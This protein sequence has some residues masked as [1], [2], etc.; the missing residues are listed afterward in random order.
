MTM[1]HTKY[2]ALKGNHNARL[3]NESLKNN[4]NTAPLADTKRIIPQTGA[5][6]PPEAD[7]EHA[8]KWVD[9]GSLL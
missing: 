7:V 5:T 6:I 9:D 4:V 3:Y 1:N 2:A 8:K